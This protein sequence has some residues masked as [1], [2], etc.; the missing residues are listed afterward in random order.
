MHRVCKR[1]V[2]IECNANSLVPCEIVKVPLWVVEV[3]RVTLASD[4]KNR[5]SVI[6]TEA[7]RREKVLE[8]IRYIQVRRSLR[9]VL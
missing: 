8:R 3:S 7:R 9:S 5:V 2:I 6:A 4:T 1:H